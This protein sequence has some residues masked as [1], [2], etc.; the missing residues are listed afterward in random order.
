MPAWRRLGVAVM[1]VAGLGA[2]GGSN[3]DVMRTSKTLAADDSAPRSAPPAGEAAP[4]STTAP[5]APMAASGQSQSAVGL[6]AG[7]TDDNERWDDY[8][9]YRRSFAGLGLRVHDVDVAERHVF[10]VVDRSGHPVLGAAV[11][12]RPAGGGEPVARLTT[13][14]D[15]RAL[16]FP[17][18]T[19]GQATGYEAE[20]SAG[21][22]SQTVRFDRQATEHKVALDTDAPPRTRLDVLFLVDATGSMQ[23]EIDRLKDNMIAVSQRIAA[24]PAKPDVRFALTAYRDQGDEFVTRT[25]DFT[26][27][28]KG[29]TDNIAGLRAAGGGDTPEALSAG[30]RAGLDAGWRGADTVKLV[31]LVADAPPQMDDPE[32]ADYAAEVVR[33]AAMGV[34]VHPIASSGLDDQGEYVFRQLAEITTGRF[35][36]LTY[37]PDGGPGDSTSMHVDKYAVLSLDSLVVKL[38]EEELA[39]SPSGQ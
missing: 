33:A 11:T 6:T 23:D 36:F 30:L 37:G 19:K 26:G 15:G 28:V 14:A 29:F 8:L 10:R 22:A 9:S 4:A 27:D 3:A 13:Y 1:V 21:G 12:V 20:V 25:V 16:F 24:L 31:F 17:N 7:S 38:V 34:K 2:C 32:G 39:G 5:G 35:V 18:A